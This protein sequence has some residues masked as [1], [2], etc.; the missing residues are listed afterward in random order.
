MKFLRKTDGYERTYSKSQATKELLKDNRVKKVVNGLNKMTIYTN[1]IIPQ[2]IHLSNVG[3][4]YQGK[5]VGTYKI[6][7]TSSPRS[8]GVWIKREEGI[9]N[10]QRDD[11]HISPHIWYYPKRTSICLGNIEEEIRIIKSHK[12]WYWFVKR[13]LDLLGD[14]HEHRLDYYVSSY[15]EYHQKDKKKEWKKH[16]PISSA[17]PMEEVFIQ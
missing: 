13:M 5:P 2:D 14:F 4:E 12:D 7:I 1:P 11:N 10:P 8:L 6:V 9:L 3:S 17:I 16:P 15:E